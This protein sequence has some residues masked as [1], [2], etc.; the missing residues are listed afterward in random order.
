[1]IKIHGFLFLI[2]FLFL[3]H[4]NII[5]TSQSINA[6]LELTQ[7]ENYIVVTGT[8]DSKMDINGLKVILDILG[9][10]GRHI[11]NLLDVNINLCTNKRKTLNV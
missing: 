5:F 9:E 11:F 8:I 4:N 7:N 1:M 10:N 3:I 6:Q 2:L